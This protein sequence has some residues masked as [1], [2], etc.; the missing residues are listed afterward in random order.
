MRVKLLGKMRTV[1]ESFWV[2][3]CYATVF[4]V[5]EG[6]RAQIHGFPGRVSRLTRPYT[7]PRAAARSLEAW[8]RDMYWATRSLVMLAGEESIK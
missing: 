4:A 5:P 3:G 2:D 7:T 8:V 1:G 6:Y